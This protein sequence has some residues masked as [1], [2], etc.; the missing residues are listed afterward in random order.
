MIVALYLTP[1]VMRRIPSCL[2]LVA[3]AILSA[4]ENRM[5]LDPGNPFW[6][7][8]APETYR[9]RFETTK[10]N[11]VLEATRALAPHGADRFYNL[12]RAGF[13]DDSRFYRVISGR[14]VQ[15]GIAGDPKIDSLWRDVRIPPDPE[16]AHNVRASFAFAMV[17][18]DAR[19]TQ[20]FIATGDMTA[21]DGTGFAPFGRVME[22]M[23]VLERLYSG[24]GEHSGGG[25]RAGRQQ[26]LFE[27]GNR[28]LDQNF[29]QLDKLLRAVIVS[30]R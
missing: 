30:G 11:F 24:Y 9:A 7:A 2:P 1:A 16:R 17:T 18:P 15:F 22:G 3:I 12:I 19:T 8:A 21:Q 23:D 6:A 26:R 25:M 28:Y 5:L 29:P 10:G 14:F 20:I 4:A 13:Y 27:E